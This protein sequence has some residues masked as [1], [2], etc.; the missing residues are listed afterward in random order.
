MIFVIWYVIGS[1]PTFEQAI[2]L[3]LLSLSITNVVK[4]S[5]LENKF[6]NLKGSF[7]RLVNDFREDLKR[8]K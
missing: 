8:Y 5:V 3:L 7:T 2:L 1:S 4:T 6:E